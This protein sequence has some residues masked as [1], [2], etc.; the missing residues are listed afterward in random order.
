MLLY[1]CMLQY[2]TVCSVVDSECFLTNWQPLL[3][4]FEV[5][6]K[7]MK[8]RFRLKQSD[9]LLSILCIIVDSGCALVDY[10]AREISRP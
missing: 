10:H 2:A 3:S 1:V 6:V 9:Y 4:I 7:K 8:N 5:S